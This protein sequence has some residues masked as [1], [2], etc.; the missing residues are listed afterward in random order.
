MS[1]NAD[2]LNCIIQVKEL[3][4]H[5]TPRTTIDFYIDPRLLAS[6]CC[7]NNVTIEP[8]VYNNNTDWELAMQ[9]MVNY[10]DFEF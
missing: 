8:S 3:L 7:K 1:L 10:K 2:I 5:V 9:S 4:N 6:W